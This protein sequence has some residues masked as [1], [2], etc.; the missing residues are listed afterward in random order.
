[1]IDKNFKLS[2]YFKLGELTQTS[3]DP[4]YENEPT[5][6]EIKHLEHIY[7]YWLEPLRRRYNIYYV[8]YP[9]EDYETSPHVEGI[10]INQGF[11]SMQVS[12]AMARAGLKPS[13]TSNHLRGCAVDI[14]C[15]GVE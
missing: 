10:V 14:R 2:Q 12:E 7:Q 1:M 5:V 15:A 13:P 8:L 3:Y 11:R 6:I 4:P 9:H